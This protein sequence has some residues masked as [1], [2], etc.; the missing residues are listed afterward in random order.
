MRAGGLA[1]DEEIMRA[2]FGGGVLEHPVGGGMA[3][4]NL[5]L[6]GDVGERR[7]VDADDSDAFAHD[8]GV[9]GVI[10]RRR[11]D[12]PA[13]AMIVDVDGARRQ[14]PRA[15]NAQGDCVAVVRDAAGGDAEAAR[16][17]GH[18]GLR[19]QHGLD[20]HAAKRRRRAEARRPAQAAVH[21]LHFGQFGGGEIGE[22]FAH[23]LVLLVEHR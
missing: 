20:H 9:D 3:L 13:A 11:A 18:D 16:A 6:E 4:R 5:V 23:R 22:G 8:C 17:D 12:R 21:G 15:E 2:K 1:A 14:G 7:V 19:A 10:H